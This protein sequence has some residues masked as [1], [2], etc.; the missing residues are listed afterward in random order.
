MR[1][2]RDARSLRTYRRTSGRSPTK[3]SRSPGLALIVGIDR[4]MSE[5]RTITNLIANGVGAVAVA[6]WDGAPE[7]YCRE[8]GGVSRNGSSRN[9]RLSRAWC[10][11]QNSNR[12]A[13]A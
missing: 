7:I 8:E 10:R 11:R 4:F 9:S 6:A 1:L 2:N 3:R 5:C 13:M 12:F